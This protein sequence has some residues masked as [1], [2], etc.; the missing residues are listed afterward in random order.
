MFVLTMKDVDISAVQHPKRDQ[1]ISILKYQGQSFRLISTFSA[2]Q[3]AE[4]RACWREL[5]DN[6]GKTCI[7]LAEEQRYSIWG[8]VRFPSEVS[9]QVE[10]HN[11]AV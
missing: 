9:E 11:A 4:A 1:R 7:L 3:E 8:K 10:S 5:T 6:R 2:T